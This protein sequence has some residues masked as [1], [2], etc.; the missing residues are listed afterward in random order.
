MALWQLSEQQ[1]SVEGLDTKAGAVLTAALAFVGLFGA[2]ASLAVDTD[3]SGSVIAAI[4]GGVAVL[5]PFG[6][7]LFAFSRAIE[8]T[9]WLHGPDSRY[10]IQVAS[11]NPEGRVRMWLA[12]RIV[13]SLLLNDDLLRRK[14]RWFS[15]ALV[16][17]ILQGAVVTAGLV[18]IV[19]A[20]AF[21]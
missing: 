3:V 7:T 4:L 16:G 11:E 18:T 1:R 5:V 21:A 19:A 2:I 6:F 14:A 20:A 10:L 9:G 13:E 17:V 15:A 8:T 12:E